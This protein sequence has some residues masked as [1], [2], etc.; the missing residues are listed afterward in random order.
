[1][2]Q[3]STA[4]SASSSP[5][6]QA[7]TPLTLESVYALPAQVSAGEVPAVTFCLP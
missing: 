1:M 4:A 5:P 6:A 3:P 2:P 7:L